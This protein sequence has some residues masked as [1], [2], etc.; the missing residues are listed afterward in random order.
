M[1]VFDALDTAYSQSFECHP[2]QRLASGVSSQLKLDD[3]PTRLFSQGYPFNY[4][5]PGLIWKKANDFLE[6]KGN[7]TV[8]ENADIKEIKLQNTFCEKINTTECRSFTTD[9]I[10]CRGDKEMLIEF[11]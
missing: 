9:I 3:Y 5:L 11:D 2:A 1:L 7:K 4:K 10:R 8:L 6:S